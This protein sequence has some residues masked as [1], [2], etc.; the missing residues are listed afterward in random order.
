[1]DLLDPHSY[2]MADS[3]DKA[4]ALATFAEDHGAL[5]GRLQLIDE[6]DHALR[7]LD[8]RDPNVREVVR[9]AITPDQLR[10]VF[11]EHG[12]PDRFRA[13]PV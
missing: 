2:G 7:R 10:R 3:V 1:M 11:E 6:I 12:F 4:Q 13:T 9:E 5:L 8:L